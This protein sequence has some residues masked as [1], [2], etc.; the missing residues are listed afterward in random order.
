M[1][2]SAMALKAIRDTVDE[3]DRQV[4]TVL[5]EQVYQQTT[6]DDLHRERDDPPVPPEAD[7]ST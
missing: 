7:V 6:D 2:R 1:A 4:V 5:S 3:T